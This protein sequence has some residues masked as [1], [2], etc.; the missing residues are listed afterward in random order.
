MG[1]SA[2]QAAAQDGSDLLHK[3]GVLHVLLRAGYDPD[4]ACGNA[5]QPE[6]DLRCEV[7]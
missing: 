3:F 5:G 6:H 2:E 7:L 1:T 4:V